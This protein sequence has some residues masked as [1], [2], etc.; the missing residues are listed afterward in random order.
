MS[1]EANYRLLEAIPG[2]EQRADMELLGREIKSGRPVVVHLLNTENVKENQD[3]LK[4]TRNLSPEH[5]EIVLEIGEF[6]GRS[7]VVTQILPGYVSF[8]KWISSVAPPSIGATRTDDLHSAG[9]FKL[10]TLME[11]AAKSPGEFTRMFMTPAPGERD[12]HEAETTHTLSIPLLRPGTAFEEPDTKTM[13]RLPAAPAPLPA[14]PPKAQPGEFTGMFQSGP[15]ASQPAASASIK[16]LKESAGTAPSEFSSVF[17]RP[18]AGDADPPPVPL[19][20]SAPAAQP[21]EFTPAFQTGPIPP[22]P[23]PPPPFAEP[24]KAQPGEF[25]RMF[26]ASP[27]VTAPPPASTPSPILDAPKHQPSELS[28]VFKSPL[29]GK[30]E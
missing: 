28:S 29:V 21:G 12:V 17:K 18:V 23:V 8:R 5:A 26:Q 1:F 6:R 27:A 25:T 4:R 30:P 3:F 10:P 16:T 9:E 15:G 19:P 14:P 20:A 13:D 2:L 11:P 22:I 24:P 7:Y